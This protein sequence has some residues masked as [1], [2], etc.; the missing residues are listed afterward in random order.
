MTGGKTT[1]KTLFFY[2]SIYIYTESLI[3]K[4]P[5]WR[6]VATVCVGPQNPI[7][8]EA[9]CHFVLTMSQCVCT[10]TTSSTSTITATTS[11]ATNTSNTSKPPPPSPQPS[12]KLVQTNAP[13]TR[14]C[15]ITHHYHS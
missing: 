6:N 8:T 11:T 14:I 13:T 3:S 12:Q 4:N 15:P 9:A 2:S 5:Q 1:M 7:Y 10:T